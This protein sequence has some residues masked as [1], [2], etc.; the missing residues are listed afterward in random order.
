MHSLKYAHFLLSFFLFIVS[1]VKNDFYWTHIHINPPQEK[2]K[3]L[4]VCVT[5]L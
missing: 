4:F 1:V 3:G 2:K 5:V